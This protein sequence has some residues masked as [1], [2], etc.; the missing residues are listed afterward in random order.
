MH[1]PSSRFDSA[2]PGSRE[3]KWAPP[4]FLF[5]ASSSG[6]PAFPRRIIPWVV[7]IAVLGSAGVAFVCFQPSRCAVRTVHSFLDAFEQNDSAVFARKLAADYGDFAGFKREDIVTAANTVRHDLDKC[8]IYR[9]RG[10][11]AGEFANDGR[12]AALEFVL[13]VNVVPRKGGRFASSLYTVSPKVS[14]TFSLRRE[15][16]LPWDWMITAIET[17]YPQKLRRYLAES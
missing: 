15:S 17:P 8:V 14:V 6:S 1:F 4:E 7:L 3:A 12:T 2:R 11:K 10:E 16:W 13:V 5:R 9:A